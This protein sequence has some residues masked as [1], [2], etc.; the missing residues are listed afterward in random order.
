MVWLGSF[1]KGSEVKYLT[2][3]DLDEVVELF[4]S[5][6][7]EEEEEGEE[8]HEMRMEGEINDSSLS[9]C[10]MLK[11]R[12]LKK[13][14]WSAAKRVWFYVFVCLPSVKVD[15]E[16]AASVYK[17]RG[18]MLDMDSITHLTA[19]NFHSAVAQSSLTVA[20]FYLKCKTLL[21]LLTV[22]Q[23]QTREGLLC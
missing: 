3:Q 21:G 23:M 1:L 9:K 5:Q 14:K 4:A 16:V 7:K 18:N 22:R 15:D 20:L 13:S 19:D 17:N 12:E 11:W 10:P 8:E 6:E 2:L